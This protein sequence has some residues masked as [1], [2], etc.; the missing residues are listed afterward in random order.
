M[1]MKI[2]QTEESAQPAFVCRMDAAEQHIKYW[3]LHTAAKRALATNLRAYAMAAYW[4][5]RTY[6]NA[7]E[8]FIVVKVEKPQ[9]ADLLQNA[10]ELAALES[11][12]KANPDIVVL[13]TKGNNLL[14]RVMK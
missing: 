1:S 5:S 3:P 6:I 4:R 9:K 10:K 14:F 7:R 13:G 12:V 11:F 8:K 2:L